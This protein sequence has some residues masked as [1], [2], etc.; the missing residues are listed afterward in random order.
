MKGRAC[1]A[2]EC[3]GAHGSLVSKSFSCTR[4]QTRRRERSCGPCLRFLPRTPFA[5]LTNPRRHKVVFGSMGD[6]SRERHRLIGETRGGVPI[7]RE[8]LIGRTSHGIPVG[9]RTEDRSG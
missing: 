1:G 7:E 4:D 6:E 3:G 5:I 9:R 2:W 8:G